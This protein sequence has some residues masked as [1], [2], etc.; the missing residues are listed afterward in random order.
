[1]LFKMTKVLNNEGNWFKGNLHMHTTKSDGLLSPQDAVSLYK[2]A[3]YHFI[4]LTDHWIE[5]ELL[6]AE[7][8]L[9]LPGCEF[10]TGD[11]VEQGI[12][13][14]VGVFMKS[15]VE[16][17]H[18]LSLHPQKIIDEINKAGG[19][20]IL[21]HP[22]WS[23][24]NPSDCMNLT[25]L[26]GAEIYNTF[27]GLPWNCRA[28]SSI[29][30]DIWASNGKIVHCM[31][32]DDCHLYKGE[33]TRSFIMVNAKDLTP[34]SLKSAISEGNF[35][36]SQGPEFNVIEIENGLIKVSCSKVETVIFYSDT[37]WSRNRVVTGGITGAVYKIESTD[38]YVR[39]ELIDYS[40]NRAWSSPFSV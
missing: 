19:L 18:S 13:H 16:L 6:A 25:G 26:C 32:A 34:D 36:S 31:A 4:A 9:V 37:L 7:N 3:G 5:S 23:I 15:K 29:Y 33:E 39:V 21:A 1:M 27:S 20:A 12:Y 2:K 22:A 40:G 28:D 35:Y 38:S 24:T 10:N 11:A 17:K 8:F 30:F 14:I